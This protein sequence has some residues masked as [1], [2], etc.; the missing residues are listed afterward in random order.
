M[1]F[2]FSI[3]YGV[4]I[5]DVY[6]FPEAKEELPVIQSVLGLAA[7]T[8]VIG[9]VPMI[10]AKHPILHQLGFALFFGTI[11]TYLGTRWGLDQFLRLK[12][13]PAKTEKS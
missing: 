11:G 8:N 7:A 3:D 12:K 6:A 2:G 9:F 13:R 5:T 1:V 10:F 4:F